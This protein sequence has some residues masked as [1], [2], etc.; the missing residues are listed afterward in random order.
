MIATSGPVVV[1]EDDEDDHEFMV[2]V[3]RQLGIPNELK[4]FTSGEDVYNYLNTTSDQP[5]III[6]EVRLQKMDGIELRKKVLENEKIRRKSIPFVFFT[7]HADKET[8]DAAYELLVQG[9][10]TKKYNEADMK[11]VLGQIINYWKEC[12]H[13]NNV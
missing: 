7:T 5:F 10:F 6:S 11:H 12:K 9:Y 1:V 2:S 3:Y 4:I 13:P 8:V